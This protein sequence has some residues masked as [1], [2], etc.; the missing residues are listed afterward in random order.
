MISG[1]SLVLLLAWAAV[2]WRGK[3]FRRAA[4]ARVLRGGVS[5]RRFFGRLYEGYKSSIGRIGG[6]CAL[7]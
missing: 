5:A 3:T 7:G 1:V 4:P 2:A 6:A